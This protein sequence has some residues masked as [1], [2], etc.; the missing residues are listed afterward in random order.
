MTWARRDDAGT[1]KRQIHEAR[2]AV[3]LHEHRSVTQQRDSHRDLRRMLVLSLA[4][5]ADRPARPPAHTFPRA[6]TAPGAW[7]SAAAPLPS[8]PRRGRRRRVSPRPRE[9][10]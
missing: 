4:A 1:E 2:R 7:V 5:A 3:E 8:A 6:A 10:P 9:A